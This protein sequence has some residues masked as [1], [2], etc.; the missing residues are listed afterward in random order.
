MR[1]TETFLK[2]YTYGVK[3]EEMFLGIEPRPP[4]PPPNISPPLTSKEE[5]LVLCLDFKKAFDSVPHDIVL[6]KV[7]LLGF[8]GNFWKIFASYLSKR[9]L[10][11]A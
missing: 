3:Y 7:E 4:P 5:L 2:T 6:Q 10:C 9:K 8:G 11:K 1:L